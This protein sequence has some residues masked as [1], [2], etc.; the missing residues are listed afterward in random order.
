[1]KNNLLAALCLLFTFQ[2]EFSRAQNPSNPCAADYWRA[3]QLQDPALLQQNEAFEEQVLQVFQEKNVAAA[4]TENVLTIPVVVHIIH[5]NGVENLSD[6]QVQQAINWLN[7]ALAN[8]DNF[9]QGSGVNTGIQFASHNARP[10]I[11]PPTVL[12][13]TK[14]RSP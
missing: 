13:A 6:A 4:P 9:N 1:M 5:D 8:Q 2:A 7:Q 10:I 12:P 3:V 11:C 14:A